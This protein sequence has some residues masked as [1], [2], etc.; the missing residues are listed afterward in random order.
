MNE[1][2]QEMGCIV[3]DLLYLS[4]IGE[5]NLYFDWVVVRNESNQLDSK[6]RP[7]FNFLEIIERYTCEN[8]GE[9]IE[10]LNPMLCP[11]HRENPLLRLA[12]LSSDD[13][14]LISKNNQISLRNATLSKN[15]YISIDCREYKETY[16]SNDED[17]EDNYT[18]PKLKLDDLL[19]KT[20]DVT[21][22]LKSNE[23]EQKQVI[24]SPRELENLSKLVGLL[25]I[26]LSEKSGNSLKHGEKISAAAVASKLELYLDQSINVDGLSKESIRKKVSLGLKKIDPLFC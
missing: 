11:S 18:F 15:E 3:E 13:I 10:V 24:E 5:L 2:S 16:C 23:P 26:A 25:T 12:R 9:Y 7:Y 4:T 8:T 19:V 22:L 14:G 17:N 20:A 6:K 1:A 21:L